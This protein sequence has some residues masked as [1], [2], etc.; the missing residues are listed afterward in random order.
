[1]PSD[2]VG[3]ARL[4]QRMTSDERTHLDALARGHRLAE[5]PLVEALRDAARP[6]EWYDAARYVGEPRRGSVRYPAPGNYSFEEG[7]ETRPDGIERAWLA[8]AGEIE[9]ADLGGH[10]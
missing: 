9:V 4:C 8:V 7:S 6:E 1:M 5:C 10:P 3:F 2:Y